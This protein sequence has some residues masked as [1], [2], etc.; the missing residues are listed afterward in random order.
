MPLLNAT[1]TDFNEKVYD[2]LREIFE[3]FAKGTKM[4]KDKLAKFTSKATD[5]VYCDENDDWILALIRE[6]GNGE[7]YLEIDGFIKFYR[8]SA[9][10]SD[11]KLNTVWSNIYSLG[12]DSNLRLKN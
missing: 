9:L 6:Y 12:Y 3:T 2:I 7:D 10:Q 11:S 4:T 8:D 5:G 1:K